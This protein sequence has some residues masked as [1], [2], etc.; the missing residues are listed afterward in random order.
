MTWF[1][2]LLL[3][4]P[5]GAVPMVFLFGVLRTVTICCVLLLLYI[6]APFVYFALRSLEHADATILSTWRYMMQAD[7]LK[8][9]VIIVAYSGVWI[10]AGIAAGALASFA[11][12]R[13]K[14]H[15][16]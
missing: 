2:A 14:G 11:Y 13:I 10:A 6:I 12:S 4:L 1:A 15:R 7:V 16:A 9:L 5:F 8:P 3:L